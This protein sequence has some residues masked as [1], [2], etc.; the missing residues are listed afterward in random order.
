VAVALPGAQVG[1]SD[2]LGR[3]D[4]LGGLPCLRGY[5]EPV[6]L[7]EGFVDL[8]QHLLLPLVQ[9]GIGEDDGARLHLVPVPLGVEDAGAHVQ[10]LGGDPQRLGDLLQHLRA[11]LAQPALDLTQIRIG[12]P[13]GIG[14][15]PQ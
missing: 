15:L 2:R 5:P 9:R 14:E 7:A 11:R 1:Q 3:L 10:R 13:G 8:E 6:L 12:H 4:R